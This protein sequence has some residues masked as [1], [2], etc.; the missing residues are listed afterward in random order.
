MFCILFKLGFFT[1]GGGFSLLAQMQVEFV[2]KRNW[3]KEEDLINITSMA[4][5]VPGIMI[6]NATVMVGYQIGG[7]VCAVLSLM[8][9]VIP[10]IIVMTF[11]TLLYKQ[12]HS[13]LYVSRAL[14]GIQCAVIPIMSSA[15]L[16]FKRSALKTGTS[17][18]IFLTALGLSVFTGTNLVFVVILG[19]L[20]GFVSSHLEE[21]KGKK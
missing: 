12:F 16:S 5:S 10:S 7:A 3:M 9:M 21:R 20:L 11:I 6:A 2:E 14:S 19:G 13:N 8:G 1:F 18:M 4:R 15:A 17:Y